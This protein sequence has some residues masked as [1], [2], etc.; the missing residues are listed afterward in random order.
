MKKYSIL[1]L[2]AL[3]TMS[4]NSQE[5]KTKDNAQMKGNEEQLTETPKGS[6]KINKEFDEDGNLI[7]YDSIYSWSSNTDLD[8]LATMDKDSVL[9]SMQSRFYRSFSDF[10]GEGYPGFF[11]EDSLFTKQFFT[12]DFFESEFGQDFMDIDRVRERM[13]H[14]QRKFLERY[15]SELGKQEEGG[16]KD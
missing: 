12:N 6:W 7:R 5:N 11:S 8:D 16:S 3:L 1:V 9:K 15:Q 14:M 4:C 10:N 13:E 2:S